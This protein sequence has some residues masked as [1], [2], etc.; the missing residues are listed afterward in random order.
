MSSE[1]F[2]KHE[3]EFQTL[4]ESLNSAVSDRIP[5]SSGEE[6]KRLIR[7]AERRIEDGFILVH[8]MEEELKPAPGT[9]RIQSLSKVRSYRRDL[10][11][12]QNKLRQLSSGASGRDS[13]GPGVHD[14]QAE[15][16]AMQSSQRSRLLQGTDTLMRAS[17]SID[18]SRRVAAETDEVAVEIIGDLGEQKEQL[19]RTQDRVHGMNAELSKSRKILNSMGRKLITNKLILGFIILLE[20]AILAAIL[21]LKLK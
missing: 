16:T 13:F 5:A 10:E 15:I 8:E 9:Y 6:R 11:K 20:M 14:T 12:I 4:Y 1:Q 7:E 18:R 3:D 2:E 19:V 17:D 21:Y